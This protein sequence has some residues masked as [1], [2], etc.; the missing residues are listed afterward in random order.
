MPAPAI[1]VKTVSPVKVLAFFRISLCPSAFSR[2]PGPVMLPL[3]TMSLPT[4]K[5]A[6][7][8]PSL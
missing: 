2:R 5:P 4:L 7:N 8:V 1:L 3:T 6:M